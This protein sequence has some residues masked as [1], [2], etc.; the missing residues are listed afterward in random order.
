MEKFCISTK[1]RNISKVKEAIYPVYFTGNMAD[2]AAA[3]RKQIKKYRLVHYP[4]LFPL[5]SYL[6]FNILSIIHWMTSKPLVS[7]LLSLHL[8]IPLSLYPISFSSLYHI[9][10]P[11]VSFPLSLIHYPLYY[12]LFGKSEVELCVTEFVSP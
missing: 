2:P 8:F 12:I 9:P 3:H 5:I 4:H 10:Y 7:Y 11:S 1:F 6:S